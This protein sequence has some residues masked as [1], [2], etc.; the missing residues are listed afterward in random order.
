[1]FI[2][3]IAPG[4]ADGLTAE[5]YE[6]ERA[7]WGFLPGFVQAFS[8]HPEIYRAWQAL[9]GE[10][11]GGMDRRR[12]ELATLAAA[13]TLRSTCCAVAHG[14]TLRDRFL[15]SAQVIDVMRDHHH[16]GLDE[17]EVVVMDFA[18]RV[19]REPA[20]VTREEVDRLRSNGLSD[21]EIFDVV[22]AVGARAFFAT[23]I[24]ALGTTAEPE[25]VAK[26]EPELVDALTV[27]RPA[28]S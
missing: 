13:R 28:R 5:I 14:K 6:S 19:A 10:V 8:H 16:A 17:A 22:V 24:E 26:L 15:P 4:A 3:P 9:I 7:K 21:R 2:D 25:L 18:E 20:A 23:V 11:Y 12:C 27:G 1:V